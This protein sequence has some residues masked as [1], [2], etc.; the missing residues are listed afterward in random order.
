MGEYKE[1]RICPFMSKPV[2]EGTGCR[3][4]GIRRVILQAIGPYREYYMMLAEIRCM[5]GECMAWKDG[6]CQLIEC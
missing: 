3:G 5:E 4:K 6:K 1:R 2:S